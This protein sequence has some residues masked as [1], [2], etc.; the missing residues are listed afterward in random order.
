MV[1]YVLRYISYRFIHDMHIGKLGQS[2]M[3]P[4]KTKGLSDTC[5]A[6]IQHRSD[7]SETQRKAFPKC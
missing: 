5:F 3:F 6:S 2:G 1:Q 7:M 4:L